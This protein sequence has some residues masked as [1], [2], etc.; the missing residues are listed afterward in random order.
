L[1]PSEAMLEASGGF[2]AGLGLASQLMGIGVLSF[3]AIAVASDYQ[4]G[5]I[6]LLAQAEPSRL[7]LLLGKVAALLLFTL[8]GTLLATL[9]G[10]GTAYLLAPSFDISTSAW[11]TDTTVTLL[12]SFRDLSLSMIVWGV[13]GFTIATLSR[14]AGLS[15]AVGIG[16]VVVFET[17]IVGMAADV[18]DW[19]PGSILTA[20]AAGGTPNIEFET[21]VA[22]AAVYTLAGII[23]SGAV[24]QRREIT[25]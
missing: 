13:I 15:I 23:I 10:A 5:L 19:M 9:A 16:W 2:V 21:A 14:S 4:T 17:M 3:W 12:E 18:A 25:Y 24:T 1:F 22:L 6:R 8:V 20:L 11:G 7:R